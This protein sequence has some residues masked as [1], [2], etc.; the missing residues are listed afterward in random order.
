[1]MTVY[2]NTY[3]GKLCYQSPESPCP[4]ASKGGNVLL[5]S[6]TI[7]SD[8]KTPYTD[9]TQVGPPI[10]SFLR[11]AGAALKSVASK[12]STPSPRRAS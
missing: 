5:P 4:K 6:M 12:S 3:S 8:S 11:A 2:G 7:S 1:M 10:M 9:A